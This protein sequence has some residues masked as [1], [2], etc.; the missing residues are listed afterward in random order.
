M[1]ASVLKPKSKQ[2]IINGLKKLPLNKI[3]E[4]I[5]KKRFTEELTKEILEIIDVN[6]QNKKGETALMIACINNN[7]KLVDLLLETKKINVNLKNNE[8]QTALMI[9]C[10]NNSS[11]I[12]K[13]LINSGANVNLLNDN[14]ESALMYAVINRDINNIKLL[15][16]SNA[17]IDV[18][19]KDKESALLLSFCKAS[20]EEV[21][22]L[23]ISKGADIKIKDKEGNNILMLATKYNYK[24]VVKYL[25]TNKIK[26]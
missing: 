17:N 13:S 3:I 18:I 15:L 4:M 26:V 9:A 8:C 7:F 16:Q 12:V 21:T 14:K 19:N 24:N 5:M 25:F 2:E 20:M 11:D 10:I 1:I 23:L 6:H 22:L